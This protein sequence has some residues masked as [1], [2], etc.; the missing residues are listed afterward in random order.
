VNPIPLD[1]NIAQRLHEESRN[2]D[3]PPHVSTILLEAASRIE[4]LEKEVECDEQRVA[5]LMGDLGDSEKENE[6]LLGLI[7][8]SIKLLEGIC[9]FVV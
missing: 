8:Q 7:K 5:D 4:F 6:R 3:L 2:P 1:H 9:E